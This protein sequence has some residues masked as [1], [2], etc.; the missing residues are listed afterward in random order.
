MTGEGRAGRALLF[1]CDPIPGYG[2]VFFPDGLFNAAARALVKIIEPGTAVK[3]HG[4]PAIPTGDFFRSGRFH[5]VTSLVEVRV[6]LFKKL[7][8]WSR[9]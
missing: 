1:G 6:L 5:F 2:F 9:L 8:K 7:S 4:A 3:F